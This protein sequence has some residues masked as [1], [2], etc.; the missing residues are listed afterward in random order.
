[1]YIG[2]L[3]QRISKYYCTRLLLIIETLK[4]S[5]RRDPVLVSKVPP[6]PHLLYAL[7][8]SSI[9]LLLTKQS[10]TPYAQP[11]LLAPLARYFD[12]YHRLHLQ[13]VCVAPPTNL[14]LSLLRESFVIAIG[15]NVTAAHLCARSILRS[16][17]EASLGA[18]LP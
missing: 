4:C 10:T 2:P 17:R 3:V 14:P 9:W 16:G 12:S 8:S 18:S 15:F 6:H 7:W 5:T 1:M 11:V 13:S